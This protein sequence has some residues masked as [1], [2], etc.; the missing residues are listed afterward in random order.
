[1]KAARF[2]GVA[3]A[4]LASPVLARPSFPSLAPD[5]ASLT[6]D[7][8][9]SDLDVEEEADK[10]DLART[11]GQVG[12][13][14]AR[15][16]AH[17]KAFY[18]LTRAGLLPVG[19]GFGALVTHAMHVERAHRV[20]A[21]DLRD[22]VRIHGHAEDLEHALERVSRDRVDLTTQRQA[23]DAARI[24]AQDEMRRQ[25][26]FDRA[27][28]T[29]T[30]VGA[31]YVPVNGGGAVSPLDAPVSGFA[32]ARGRLLFPLV[33]RADVRPARRDG[34]DGPG[35]ELRAPAGSVVRAVFAGRVAFA[36]RYGPYGRIVILDHGSH[37]FTVSGN[38]DEVDVKPGEDVGA[39][40]R[41]GT[42][43]DDG[44]GPMLYFEVRQGSQTVAPGPWLGL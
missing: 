41:I 2:V 10:V 3:L 9:L 18:K 37:Y 43:G 36:D 40:D 42:V 29:S 12:V 5:L 30:G 22:E 4:L 1:M 32:A 24:A 33:G 16:I 23:M 26:A 11:A 8:R 15:L 27:F 39:G 35:L 31:D 34:T 25:A 21:A 17:G 28:E 7:K 13:V 44:A 19:G 38:L 20:L 6:L 14:R